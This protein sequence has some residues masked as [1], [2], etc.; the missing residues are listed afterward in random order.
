M[1]PS[2]TA[3]MDKKLRQGSVA[4]I[5]TATFAIA[6]LIAFETLA[7][8][9]FPTRHRGRVDWDRTEWAMIAGGTCALI[10]L[11]V[12]KLADRWRS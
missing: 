9:M 10:G 6:G 11:A 5:C 3:R 7:P 2:Y 12:G 4:R 8:G 1:T